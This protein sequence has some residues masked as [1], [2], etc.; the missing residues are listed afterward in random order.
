MSPNAN[1]HEADVF[2][3]SNS[4][5]QLPTNVLRQCLSFLGP[6]DNYYFLASVS[7]NFKT[8]VE[9]LYGE[10][11]NTS[12]E[13]I[14]AT[15]S[16]CNH[17]VDLIMGDTELMQEEKAVL[18]CK[19]FAAAFKNDRVDI[20]ERSIT[21]LYEAEGIMNNCVTFAITNKSTEI[22][23]LL[24]KDLEYVQFLKEFELENDIPL[25]SCVPAAC[26]V[27]MIKELID[28]GVKFNGES[29]V[30]A[31]Q[32]DDLETFEYLLNVVN[33]YTGRER[34]AIFFSAMSHRKGFDAF[35]MLM[36]KGFTY[37][38]RY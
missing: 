4:A 33:V 11:R 35:Q 29:L 5:T 2:N 9:Q 37:G 38:M 22:M 23:R 28:H 13:S 27:C 15:V 14:I 7:K 6:S 20:F 10:N 12:A 26:D 17:V 25:V 19:I 36:G 1:E 16:T 21:P 24:I 31:L 30:F 18:T 32:R 8:A 34:Q 3:T